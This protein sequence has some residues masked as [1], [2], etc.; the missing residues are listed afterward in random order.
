M[1]D[2][3]LL[4]Q[5]TCGIG[6]ALA[7]LFLA[8]PG[9]AG[10]T[11][12]DLLQQFPK[13]SITSVEQADA[14]LA[15][16][17]RERAEVEARYADAEY[18]CYSKFFSTPCVNRAKD[19]RREALK[20]IRAVEV[21][22]NAYKRRD[23]VAQRDKVLEQRRMQEEADAP[24]RNFREQENRQKAEQR[25]ADRAARQAAPEKAPGGR[26][27]A[28]PRAADAPRVG[29]RDRI[30]EH[31]EKLRQARQED[32]A[33]A[34]RRAQNVADY[35]K[36]QQE[37]AERQRRVAEKVEER[38]RKQRERAAAAAAQPNQPR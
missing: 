29:G 36:K 13:G 14:A 7:L 25:A 27:G 34:E 32:A 16:V 19:D 1:S 31:E 23:T 22:A 18:A 30:A 24:Q 20:R 21:E 4:P 2:L 10:A 33:N 28:T 15:Q 38:E 11:P 8:A 9:P 35:Q 5:K 17:P 26:P 12:E 37:A 3:S 6:L